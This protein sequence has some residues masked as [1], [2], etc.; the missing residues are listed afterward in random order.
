MGKREKK[1]P[2]SLTVNNR[3]SKSFYERVWEKASSVVMAATGDVTPKQSSSIN[4]RADVNISSRYE[5]QR[6]SGIKGNWN[7]I[8]P[9]AA[10]KQ[11]AE[12]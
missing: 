6:I 3:S 7:I 8:S 12:G 11:T 1:D 4:G 2:M 5:T 10:N 9:R